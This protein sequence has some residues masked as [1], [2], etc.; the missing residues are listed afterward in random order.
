MT[1]LFVPEAGFRLLV[2]SNPLL[3]FS[4][5]TCRRR[6][7]TVIHVPGPGVFWHVFFRNQL[8]SRKSSS[9][10]GHPRQIRWLTG[11]KKNRINSLWSDK[12]IS[13]ILEP[14]KIVFFSSRETGALKCSKKRCR[15]SSQ[16]GSDEPTLAPRFKWPDNNFNHRIFLE[17]HS[18]I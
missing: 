10:I 2:L 15:P 12:A 7:I 3:K 9:G 11:D 13:V 14:L 4:I 17:Y 5:L 1:E 6:Q 8:D 18:E 16:N